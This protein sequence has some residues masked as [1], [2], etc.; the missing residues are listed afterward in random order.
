MMHV[1][2]PA[3]E[4]RRLPSPFHLTSTARP[5][6]N[7]GVP[8]L[9]VNISD[10]DDA[11]LRDECRVRGIAT[12]ADLVQALITQARDRANEARVDALIIEGLES[13]PRHDLNKDFRQE[14]H[15][16]LDARLNTRRS[17]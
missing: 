4:R 12:P 3:R 5:P 15:R 6:H 11:F 8:S 9:S 1:R 7:H 13:L 17:A 10:N 2:E 14:L 16:G